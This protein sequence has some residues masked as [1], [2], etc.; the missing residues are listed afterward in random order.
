MTP[1]DFLG[2]GIDISKEG[3]QIA[4]KEYSGYKILDVQQVQYNRVVN[5]ESLEQ[6]I[7]MTPLSWGASEEKVQK[8]LN[9]GIYSIS[10]DYSIIIGNK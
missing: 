10:V 7:K 4:S 1:K 6:L 9:T 8:A 3:I 2:V 5:K